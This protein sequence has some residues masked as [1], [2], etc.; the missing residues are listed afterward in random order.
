[1][2]KNNAPALTPLIFLF[3]GIIIPLV[4][5]KFRSLAYH[6]ALTATLAGTIVSISN[7]FYVLNSG[8]IQYY[9]GGWPPPIGIEYVLDPL[10][11]FLTA[12]IN[13]ITFIVLI[14]AG[15]IVKKEIPEHKRVP[16]YALVMLFLCGCNGIILTGDFFNLY[17]FL[18]ISSLA[19]YGMVAV[20]DKKSPIS[21]FRYLIMGTVG[22]GFYLLGVGFLYIHTGSL[23]MADI[24]GILPIL[25]TNPVVIVALS[26]MVLGLGIKMALFPLHGWLPDAYTHAP[27]ASSSIMAPIGVKIGAYGILRILLFV[28]GLKFVTQ[29]FPIAQIIAW[30]SAAGIIYGSIMAISQDEMKRMLAYSSI[31]QIGY[32]GLGIGLANPYGIIGAVLH[33]LNHGLMKAC[34]FLVA[35]NFRIKL[36]HSNIKNFDDT[37]RKKMPWTTAAFAVGALAMV[38]I[39]PTV[40]F[41]SKWYLALGTIENKSWHFLVVILLSSLLNAVYFFRIIEKIYFKSHHGNQVNEEKQPIKRSEVTASMLVPTLVLAAALFIIGLLNTLIVKGVL[42]KVLPP[43]M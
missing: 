15:T 27:S 19:L 41:F 17:V 5:F 21:A 23:N 34:L 35:G 3:A 28:F 37:L 8:P 32:I 25:G 40:G 2:I 30:L 39:P 38:G 14:N 20:G 1:M 26:L 42:M 10:S 11:A 29:V 33:I 13:G 9:F 24:N 22:G 6:V 7:V 4:A 16:Y 12:V 18:E 36:G 31:S 43:G